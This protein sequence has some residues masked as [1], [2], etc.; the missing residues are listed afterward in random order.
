MASDPDMMAA[1][2]RGTK[3]VGTMVPIEELERLYGLEARLTAAEAARDEAQAEV[4]NLLGDLCRVRAAA[5]RA[6]VALGELEAERDAALARAERLEAALRPF[7]E[8]ADNLEGDEHDSRHLWE[9]PEAM[10]LTAGD[11]RAARAVIA[12]PEGDQQ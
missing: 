8:A 12:S 4:R 1:L 2:I 9:S 11:L 5:G 3:H 7:A 6:D 10:M